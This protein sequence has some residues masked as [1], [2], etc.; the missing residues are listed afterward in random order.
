MYMLLSHSPAQH[1]THQVPRTYPAYVPSTRYST[2]FS[3]G[4]ENK[5]KHTARGGLNQPT[6]P[7]P[8]SLTATRYILYV[9][10]VLLVFLRSPHAQDKQLDPTS[11]CPGY[12]VSNIRGR[13]TQTQATY[14][15]GIIR[16]RPVTGAQCVVIRTK[17]VSNKGEI[18]F[19]GVHRSS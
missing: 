5:F 14:V 10:R 9:I 4:L 15:L 13:Q 1:V 3:I 18:I 16:V 6:T 2:R 7:I 17:S 8:F 19:F 11:T 12:L